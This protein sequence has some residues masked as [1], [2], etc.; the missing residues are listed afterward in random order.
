MALE[1][2]TTRPIYADYFP[3]AM[4]VLSSPQGKHSLHP[5]LLNLPN[6]SMCR[7]KLG[8]TLQR[9]SMKIRKELRII[10]RLLQIIALPLVLARA[11]RG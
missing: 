3:S 6:F 5:Y 8:L 1:T 7:Q 9:S 11:W 4:K 10:Q 2:F